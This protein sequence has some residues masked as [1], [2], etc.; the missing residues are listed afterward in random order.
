M[1][2]YQGIMDMDITFKKRWREGRAG[3]G[4]GQGCPRHTGRAGRGAAADRETEKLPLRHS[5]VGM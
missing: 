1:E 5:N 2:N 3:L 4:P